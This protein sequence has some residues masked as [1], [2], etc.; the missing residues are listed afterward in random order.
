[1][2]ARFRWFLTSISIFSGISIA[3][4]FFF[5]SAVLI[6]RLCPGKYLGSEMTCDMDKPNITCTLPWVGELHSVVM[7]I[8]ALLAITLTVAIPIFVAP[9]HKLYVGAIS[10][11]LVASPLIWFGFKAGGF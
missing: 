10:F 1:M 9:T 5:V 8:A 6:D 11:L 7:V 4:I 3:A 2:S